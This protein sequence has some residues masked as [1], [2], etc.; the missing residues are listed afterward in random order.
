MVPDLAAGAATELD[1]LRAGCDLALRRMLDSAPDMVVAVG[2]DVEG[3]GVREFEAEAYGSFARYGVDMTVG[4]SRVGRLP[5][6]LS[7]GA[8]LLQRCAW[9]GQRLFVALGADVDPDTCLGTGKQLAQR[10]NRV[11]LLVLGDGSAR[12]S[13]TAPGYVDERAVPYDSQVCRAL[14]LGDVGA[15]AQL[16]PEVSA[17]LL[18]GGRTAWQVLAGAADGV[19]IEAS[20][21]AEESPYGVDYFVASWLA[22]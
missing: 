13:E 12:R 15:L 9:S 4:A 2:P 1:A 19:D 3:S 16:D 18:V 20:L 8:W 7:V 6:S 22:Q 14:Q 17:E 10:A 21:L 5:L 11:A